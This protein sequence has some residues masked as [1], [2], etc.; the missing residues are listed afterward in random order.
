MKYSLLLIFTVLLFGC[1][2]NDE[3][4]ALP[5]GSPM[6]YPPSDTNEWLSISPNEAGWNSSS[7]NE[8]L[9]FLEDNNTRAFIMLKDGKIVIEEYFGN[10]L[11]GTGPFGQNSQWYWASAG[12][13]LTATLAGIAQ[14]EG[15][16]NI[17]DPTSDYLGKGWTSLPADKEDLIT[18]RDQLTMTTGLDHEVADLN[19]TLPSCLTYKADAGQQWFYHNAPYTLLEKVIENA[20]GVDYNAYTDQ[21]LEAVTG[22]RGQWIKQDYN[23]V[24][25]STARDMARF[26]LL[27][28]N[29]GEW[30]GTKVLLDDAY[31]DQMVNTSQVLNPSYGYLW[32]LNGKSSI[33]FPGLPD[34]FNTSLSENAPGDLFAGLGKNGQFV[35]VIP[36][37]KLVVVRMGEAPDGSLVPIAFHNEMWEK[38]NLL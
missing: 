32:W 24:Y 38:I 6:Y 34:V 25:W 17:A 35:E 37:K 5:E 11:S 7:I 3:S 14:Q 28:L 31:Y 13:T 30:D 27:M 10:N 29:K 18:V 36:S 20:T 2:N 8:L 23:N 26:G 19:C 33:I 16:L 21:K 1:D 15:R 9:T 4:A 12:K 22:M